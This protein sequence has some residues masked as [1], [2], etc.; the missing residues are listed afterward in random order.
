MGIAVLLVWF[1]RNPDA[2]PKASNMAMLVLR[3]RGFGLMNSM[4]SSAKMETLC[5]M[6]TLAKGEGNSVDDAK[7]NNLCSG[8]II[9]MK[10]M[11]ESGAPCLSPL[12]L[13]IASPGTPFTNT[14]VV[15]VLRSPATQEVHLSPKPI[16]R[17]T[18]K[19]NGHCT[20]SKAFVMSSFNMTVGSL[21]A[22]SHLAVYC[23]SMK[24]SCKDL[25]FTKALW[26]APTS[27]GSSSA[28][29]DAS[30]IKKIDCPVDQ[31]HRSKIS[32]IHCPIHLGKQG[33]QVLVDCR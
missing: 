32:D 6:P 23:T 4:T 12:Q 5:C 24:L 16:C 14:F 33:D 29:L 8:S 13:K 17:I 31:T 25:P 22:W 3:S 20:V 2:D 1:T 28:S 18:S 11:G 30:L 27:L 21:R 15:D 19:R 9:R 26:S 10:S 7:S